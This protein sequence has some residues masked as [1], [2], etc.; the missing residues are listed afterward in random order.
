MEREAL[1]RADLHPRSSSRTGDEAGSSRGAGPT[2]SSLDPF[3]PSPDVREYH[4]TT[5]HAPADLVFGVARAFDLQSVPL[6]RGIFALRGILMGASA[7]PRAPR[8]FLEE[9]RAL[10]W[11]ALVER[12]LLFI[13]GAACRPWEANVVF[14]PIPTDRFATFAEPDQVRIVWSLE[15]VPLGATLTRLGTETRA[16]ATDESARVKFRRYWRWARFGIVS[17]RMLLLPAIRRRA[18]AEWR[19]RSGP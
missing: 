19:A 13:G 15:A 9:M 1:T 3:M 5:V 17:I 14:R 16:A 8:G 7:A 18:Q 10:G 11:G 12:P 6:V 2:S 4:A